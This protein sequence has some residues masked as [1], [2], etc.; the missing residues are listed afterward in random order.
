MTILET[1][2]SVHSKRGGRGRARTDEER[3]DIVDG[4]RKGLEDVLWMICGERRMNYA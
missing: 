1:A 4:I 2:E 3:G